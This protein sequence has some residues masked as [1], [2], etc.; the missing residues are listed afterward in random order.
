VGDVDVGCC[1]R[2]ICSVLSVDG[3][4]WWTQSLFI[5]LAVLG[6]ELREE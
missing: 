4:G 2:L 6:M 1:H 5:L 3:S